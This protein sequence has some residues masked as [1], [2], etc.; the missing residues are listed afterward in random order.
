MYYKKSKR[1][2]VRGKKTAYKKG[3]KGKMK[4]YTVARGGI[5]L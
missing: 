1:G 5:R 2:K 3:K 4:F